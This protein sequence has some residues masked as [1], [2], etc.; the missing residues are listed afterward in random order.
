[1]TKTLFGVLHDLLQEK[2]R[3]KNLTTILTNC[4]ETT[5]FQCKNKVDFKD[6]MNIDQITD[7]IIISFESRVKISPT[8]MVFRSIR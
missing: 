2:H 1:M 3:I 7:Y 6:D 8:A 5:A 4:V